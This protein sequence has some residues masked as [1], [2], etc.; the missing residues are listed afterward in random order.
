MYSISDDLIDLDEVEMNDMTE[1]F[2]HK[3]IKGNDWEQL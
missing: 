1:H 2:C 3:W